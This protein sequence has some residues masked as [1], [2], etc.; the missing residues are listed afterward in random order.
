MARTLNLT[1]PVCLQ[2][3]Y[4]L[5]WVWIQRPHCGIQSINIQ[6]CIIFSQTSFTDQT[7]ALNLVMAVTSHFLILFLLSHI[8]LGW[9]SWYIRKKTNNITNQFNC[10]LGK[11]TQRPACRIPMV[12]FIEADLYNY[13]FFQTD[14]WSCRINIG[15]MKDTIVNEGP[16]M[17]LGK[18]KNSQRLS[19]C[20]EIT[21]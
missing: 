21:Q 20:S 9:F 17:A 6:L 12:S 11:H 13:L 5:I 3:V 2:Y 15:W 10:H 4:V 8:S 7:C 1:W 19:P 14:E 16:F 18:K